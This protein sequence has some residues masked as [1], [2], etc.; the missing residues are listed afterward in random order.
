MN[1]KKIYTRKMN[2]KKTYMKKRWTWEDKKRDKHKENLLY[3][4]TTYYSWEKLQIEDRKDSCWTWEYE[5]K[6]EHERNLHDNMRRNMNMRK[7]FPNQ[8]ITYDSS[9][10]IQIRDTRTHVSQSFKSECRIFV[11]EEASNL[12][13][14]DSCWKKLQI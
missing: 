11:L 12:S 3:L 4:W 7:K 8:W 13:A 14:K 10:N 1:M 2:I 5:K 9:K 6:E